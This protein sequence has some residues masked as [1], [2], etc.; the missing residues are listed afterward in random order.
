[1]D[2]DRGIAIVNGQEIEL[3]A[4]S[5]IVIEKVENHPFRIA[6]A[7]YVFRGGDDEMI[8]LQDGIRIDKDNLSEEQKA[9]WEA[10]ERNMKDWGKQWEAYGKDWEGIN[11]DQY[12]KEMEAWG[13]Q[14]EN[15]DWK[16]FGEQWKEFGEKWKNEYAD[17]WKEYENQ[18]QEYARRHPDE[19]R[20]RLN[21]NRQQLQEEIEDARRHQEQAR[22]L[23]GEYPG[24]STPEMEL[25][26][27]HIL[28]LD[29]EGNLLALR[30]A[31]RDPF[32]SLKSAMA[33]DGLIDQ[34]GEYSILLDQDKLRI[35]G[36]RMPDDVHEKYLD[37]FERTQGYRLSGKSK[38]EISN[39]L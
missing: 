13:K 9:E 32:R 25:E 28:R 2:G 35:N 11:W 10:Y 14:W 31:E 30:S 18:L 15:Q 23:L 6:R 16:A 17:E 7:P 21:E 4:D 3:D 19:E 26:R 29:E 22:R 20:E 33:R 39:D 1:V 36:K 27:A 34:D 24:E 12:S 37:L 38:I 5:V 8:V